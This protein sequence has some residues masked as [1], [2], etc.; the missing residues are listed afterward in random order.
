MRLLITC[1]RWL[2]ALVACTLALPGVSAAPTGPDNDPKKADTPAEKI[3]KA[4]DQVTDLEI[5]DQPLHLA[6]AQLREQTKLN[7]VLDRQMLANLGIDP[8]QTPINIK[9]QNVK[10]RSALRTMLGQYNLSYA[11]VGDAVVITTEDMALYRQLRQR[12]NIELD[13]VQFAV[14][15]KQLARE[16]GTNLVADT[17]MHKESQTPVTLQLEDVPL[18]M[19]VKVMAEMAGLRSVR[20][21]NVLFV[22]SKANAAE[23][24]TDPDLMPGQ[25]GNP[26]EQMFIPG[27]PGIGVPG[28]IRIAP[29]PPAAAPV[30]PPPPPQEDKP[31]KPED[32]PA[33]PADK[34][35]GNTN[36]PKPP[37]KP[38]R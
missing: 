17:R 22:T 4:L 3:R 18:E 37:E 26:A 10:L 36:P 27:G 6:V 20:M 14:A 19:V 16:T 30:P 32:K 28:G 35:P 23:L 1:P 2:L 24:R 29:A 15:L 8:E 33:K 21:G 31:A 38:D 9:L 7:F 13:R 25:Q 5:T 34:A 12:V 11:L